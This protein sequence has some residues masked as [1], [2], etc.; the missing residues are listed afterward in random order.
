MSAPS[1]FD[2]IEGFEVTDVVA[3]AFAADGIEVPTPVQAAA[4]PHILA[5]RH[6]VLQS[7]TGTGKTLAY[8]LPVLQ[9]LRREP[10]SRAVIFAPAPELAMQTL[11]VAD[12]YKDPGIATGALIATG[13]RERQRAQVQ[14]STRL[15][16][17]T[18]GRILE[19]WLAR[20]LKGVNIV[21]LDEPAPILGGPDAG[22]LAEV[23]SR[24]EPKIQ[25]V[26]ASATSSPASEELARRIMGDAA[27]R[28]TATDDPLRGR[29]RHSYVAVGPTAAK[30]LALVRFIANNRCK[31]AIIL[32]DDA[33]LLRHLFRYL[34]ENGLEP[35]T[36]S[37][38]RSKTERRAALAAFREGRARV[39]IGSDLAMRGLDL[40]DVAWVLQYDLPGSAQAYVHRA[41]RTGRAGKAGDSVVFVTPDERPRLARFAKELGLEIGAFEGLE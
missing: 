10:A 38:E 20:K 13:R 8:L 3:G 11:R 24:P 37:S 31:R 5:G 36:I 34:G 15:V 39:L 32:V 17:G 21:V 25:L 9:R 35:V 6:V 7:G 27:V 26:L 22:R 16:V 41:G 30:D 33:R 2:Q 19:H 29:I 1:A 12:R 23:L 40:P 14:K 28:V 18:P 4:L